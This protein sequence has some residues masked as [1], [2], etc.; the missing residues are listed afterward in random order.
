MNEEQKIIQE[1][2]DKYYPRKDI[3]NSIGVGTTYIPDRTF[4][5][6]LSTLTPKFLETL[7]GALDPYLLHN[8]GEEINLHLRLTNHLLTSPLIDD[9]ELPRVF[10]MSDFSLINMPIKEIVIYKL[11]DSIS[12]I[13]KD[14][15]RCSFCGGYTKN[16]EKGNCFACGGPRQ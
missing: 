14:Y 9:L 4:E 12:S 3:T 5:W 1:Y 6:A 8:F 2:Y 7:H 16:D 15:Q 10:M 13:P 11:A